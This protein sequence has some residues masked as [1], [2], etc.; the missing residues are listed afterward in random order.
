M[1]KF[2]TQTEIRQNRDTLKEPKQIALN[3]EAED[4]QKL[5]IAVRKLDTTQNEII[6]CVLHEWLNTE[7]FDLI[8]DERIFYRVQ[9]GISTKKDDG[10][11]ACDNITEQGALFVDVESAKKDLNFWFEQ[12]CRELRKHSPRRAKHE[13]AFARLIAVTGVCDANPDGRDAQRLLTPQQNQNM[14]EA[15]LTLDGATL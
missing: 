12:E 1:I 2:R 5:K 11:L 3:I 8:M 13:I 9:H 6:R 4:W 15:A 7:A 14:D 10:S